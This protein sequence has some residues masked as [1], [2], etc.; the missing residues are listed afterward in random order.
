MKNIKLQTPVKVCAASEQLEFGAGISG[1]GS[2]FAQNILNRLYQ[3]GFAGEQNPN[4]IVYNAH[5][6]ANSLSRCAENKPYGEDD[7]FQFN[8]KWCSWEHHGNFSA[9]DLDS[10]ICKAN[11]ALESFRAAVVKSPL[12]VMT[13]SSS[14]VYQLRDGK[15]I[16]ANCHK[17]PNNEFERR[18]LSVEENLA[19][20]KNSVSDIRR[21]S[22][23]CN[24]VITVSPVRHYPGDLVLNTR[25]KANLLAAVHECVDLFDCVDY[26][27]SYE[28][29]LD[30]LRDYRF[31]NEDMLHPNELARK[32]IFQR[33]VESYF[34]KTA[35]S[36]I[37]SAEKR[38]R[39]SQHKSM[40]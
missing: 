12:F 33:F 9:V 21:I 7:F 31:F 10:A 40:S 32:I 38:F 8:N 2:C 16:V 26:F 13:P 11:T 19:C 6:I 34:S 23:E 18:L 37:A 20:L 35:L 28:I 4:G 1:V 22:P 25:S 30:E 29:V 14:V 39:A 5:S 17:V 36:E 3:L 15:Q 24:V 27:P